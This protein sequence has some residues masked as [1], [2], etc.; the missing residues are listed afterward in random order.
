MPAG[1]TA[2]LTLASS[3]ITGASIAAPSQAVVLSSALPPIS[4]KVVARIR[5]GQFVPMKDLLAD[6]MSPV[7]PAGGTSIHSA[8]TGGAA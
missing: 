7:Q 5:S 1:H 3:H 2:T 8:C 4:A 6:N